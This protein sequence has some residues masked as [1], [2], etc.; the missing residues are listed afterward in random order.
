MTNNDGPR[1]TNDEPAMT[2]L[3]ED[4]LVLHY[5]G[6]LTSGEES[7][8]AGHL[9]SCPECHENLRRLQRVLAVVDE[10]A[11]SG[12]ELPEHFERTVWA[13]LEPNLHGSREGWVSW[14]MLSPG[15]LAWIAT[16]VM[17]VGAAFMA[18]RLLPRS[19]EATATA[20]RDLR[21][22]ILLVDL[23]DHLDRSQMM[24]VELV[25][26]DAD[27]A[28]DISGERARAE[29]LV[30]ANRLY[31][32]T[33]LANGDAG[34]VD[35]LDELERVLVD[36]AASPEQLSPDRLSEVRQR[37]ESRSLLFKVR[38]VSAEVRQRQKAI[39]QT[40][41]GDRSSL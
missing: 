32:H 12:P 18:G 6:E 7:R 19:E 33:A 8:A 30:S 15:R 5:Y 25:S 29:Q 31:R 9:T 38:V 14:F 13:R 36:L 17:L 34:I 26:A 4:E 39:V 23:G 41:A 16:V 2:H 1:I 3:S 11:L 40:R 35:L 28:V 24:L 27:G 20:A 22:R 21:E 10:S 37:I